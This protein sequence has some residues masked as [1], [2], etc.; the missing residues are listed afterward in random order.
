MNHKIIHLEPFGVL[1]EPTKENTHVNDLDAKALKLLFEQEQLIVL[2]GFKTF[3]ES[4]DFS[5]YCEVWGEISIWP[6]GK[7]LD[8][9]Q[10][11]QPDDHIFDNSYMPLHWDGMYRPQVPE[12]QIFQCIKAPLS[13]QGG[14]TT[15]SNTMLALEYAPDDHIELWKKAVVNYQRRVEFYNSRTISPV[16]TKHP[17]KGYP[18]IRYN[19]PHLEKKG[20][21]VNPPDIEVTGVDAEDVEILH[22]SLHQA[23]YNPKNFYAHAWKSRD[24]VIADNFTLLHGRE[25]FISQSPRHIRRVQVLSNPPFNNPHLESY[26]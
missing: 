11:E 8:L 6:F 12:Y 14:R 20:I 13:G 26:Q 2:R 16:I 24:I 5:R 21:F 25:R 18:V 15:F 10:K 1:I 3:E 4:S 17:R 22:K 7:V 19:E 23:L 9:V